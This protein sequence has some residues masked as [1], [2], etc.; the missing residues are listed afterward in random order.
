MDHG[1]L[2]N[3]IGKNNLTSS[4][5]SQLP[6]TPY[7]RVS[8]GVCLSLSCWGLS[9]LSFVVFASSVSITVNV[10][11]QQLWW[12]RRTQFL[13]IQSHLSLIVF[14]LLLTQWSLFSRRRKCNLDIQFRTEHFSTLILYAKTAMDFVVIT[15]CCR[16]K[17]L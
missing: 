11:M 7:P 1:T 9:C 15:I 17:L 16:N 13:H 6:I 12:I 5:C 4:R 14:M 8:L 2:K 3:K 10:Y